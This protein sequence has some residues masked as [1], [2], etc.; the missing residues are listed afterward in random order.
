MAWVRGLEVD[1][2]SG[3][4]AVRRD[5]SD[6]S[7][8]RVRGAGSSWGPYRG[9]LQKRSLKYRSM[10]LRH[11]SC[12]EDRE[13]LRET[14][15]MVNPV[16]CC[17]ARC[18]NSELMFPSPHIVFIFMLSSTTD[19]QHRLLVAALPCIGKKSPSPFKNKINCQNREERDKKRY[20]RNN[21]PTAGLW[22]VSPGW[23]LNG[24]PPGPMIGRIMPG[25]PRLP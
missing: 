25:G 5:P 18:E 2:A 22:R 21:R 11:A 12:V 13:T 4:T 16:F 24:S 7:G 23:P 6:P 17:R 10:K 15:R 3:R 9:V 19:R 1:L 20:F 8:R 14:E